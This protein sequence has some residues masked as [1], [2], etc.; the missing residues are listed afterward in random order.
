ME[1]VLITVSCF[2]SLSVLQNNIVSLKAILVFVYVIL[3]KL[4]SILNPYNVRLKHKYFMAIK[5]S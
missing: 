2:H 5:N 4:D 1:Q 3:E